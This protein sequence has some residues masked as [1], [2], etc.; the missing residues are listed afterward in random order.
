MGSAHWMI[1]VYDTAGKYLYLLGS[2][3]VWLSMVL[4][5]EIVRTFILAD[6]Y[7]YYVKRLVLI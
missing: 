2:G 7:Y 1:S 5:T 4:L 3:Y 6:F